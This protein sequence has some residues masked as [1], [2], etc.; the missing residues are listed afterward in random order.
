[1]PQ[2][3]LERARE[4]VKEVKLQLLNY[5]GTPVARRSSKVGASTEKP[6]STTVAQHLQPRAPC[7]AVGRGRHFFA[8]AFVGSLTGKPLYTAVY[9]HAGLHI[10]QPAPPFDSALLA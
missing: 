6:L 9:S 10:A 5:L 3:G 4:I 1:M 2:G 7:P 8:R